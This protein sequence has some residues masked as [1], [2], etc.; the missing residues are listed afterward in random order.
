MKNSKVAN[1]TNSATTVNG[2]SSNAASFLNVFAEGKP[3]VHSDICGTSGMLTKKST[4][5][6]LK[7]LFEML[8]K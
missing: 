6:M 5:V 1:L 4:S 7:T 2:G 3:F 8:R